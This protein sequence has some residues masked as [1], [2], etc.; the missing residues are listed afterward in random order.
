MGIIGVFC[1]VFRQSGFL[2]I[3]RVIFLLS[4]RTGPFICL[5]LGFFFSFTYLQGRFR[6][7]C[8][9]FGIGGGCIKKEAITKVQDHTPANLRYNHRH[10]KSFITCRSSPHAMDQRNTRSAEV[11]IHPIH[12]KNTIPFPKPIPTHPLA[13]LSNCSSSIPTPLTGGGV[14]CRSCADELLISSSFETRNSA[15]F[16][17]VELG[18]QFFAL[19]YREGARGGLILP[20]AFGMLIGG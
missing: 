3:N 7:I 6:L 17:Y 12:K 1:A 10:Q 20:V 16:T 9:K 19:I 8:L 5:D 4:R 14:H 11:D 13:L 18:L 15:Y 2:L